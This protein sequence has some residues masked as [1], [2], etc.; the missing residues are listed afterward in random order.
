MLFTTM[1]CTKNY[2]K[3]QGSLK[4][5]GYTF[6]TAS[7]SHTDSVKTFFFFFNHI[8]REHSHLTIRTHFP[9]VFILHR[10][11]GE[12]E[13]AH[14]EEQQAGVNRSST[15]GQR[16][17]AVIVWLQ[18]SSISNDMGNVVLLLDPVEKVRHGTFGIDSDILY[19]MGL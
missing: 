7:Q 12:E 6:Y 5:F 9:K 15:A 17:F 10:I 18:A 14:Q 3:W 11:E 4:L 16:Q 13:E 1:F 19:A 8:A 2:M